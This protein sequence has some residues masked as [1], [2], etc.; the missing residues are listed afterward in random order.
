MLLLRILQIYNIIDVCIQIDSV[1]KLLMLR[2]C[3]SD[4][5]RHFKLSVD[6][7]MI[8]LESVDIDLQVYGL[9]TV[10]FLVEWLFKRMHWPPR[11][12]KHMSHLPHLTQWRI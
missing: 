2:I 10:Y 12:A 4:S 5:I 9:A 6:P 11:F 8:F 7:G 3:S 1:Q